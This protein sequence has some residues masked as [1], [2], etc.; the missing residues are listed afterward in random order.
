MK[1]FTISVL[2]ILGY[3]SNFSAQALQQCTTDNNNDGVTNTQ[4]FLNLVGQ[5]GQ[6]CTPVGIISSIT[7]TGVTN[8]GALTQG[9]EAT[10]VS[11]VISYA[12]GNGGNHTGQVVASTGVTGLYAALSAGSFNSGAGSL[13]YV[14][15]GTPATSGTASFALNIGGQTCILTRTVDAGN[16][17]NSTAHSCSATNVHNSAKNYGTLTDQQGNVY[18]TIVIGNQE[19]M[20]ENLRTSVYRNGESIANVTDNSQWA[21]LTTG[22][23]CYFENNSI[24]ECPYGKLYNWFTISDPRGVCPT[25]WHIPTDGEWTQLTNFLGGEETAGS[26][27]KSIGTDYWLSPNTGALNESGFSGLPGNYRYS[28]GEFQSTN[29]GENDFAAF[30]SLTE[31]QSIAA[32]G[33]YLYYSS[34]GINRGS[35]SKEEGHSI[36]CI[37]DA[38][39]PQGYIIGLNC[40]MAVN[41]GTLSLGIEANNVSSS[42]PYSFGN[43]GEHGG[44]FTTSTGVYGLTASLSIGSFNEGSGTLEFIINGTPDNFGEATFELNIGGQ[45]CTLTR[46]V[47]G[48]SQNYSSEHTCG[49][50]NIHN[51]E[52]TYGS[53]T[54]QQG[55]VYKTIVIG[56]QEWMAEN[57]KTTIY[58]NGNEIANITDDSQWQSLSSGAWCDFNNDIQYD[59]PYGKLYNY[60]AIADQRNLCPVGWHVPTDAEWTTLTTFLGGQNIAG[61]KMKSTGAQYWVSSNADATNESGLSCLPGGYRNFGG[62]YI[63]IG[64]YGAWW[65]STVV[66][67]IEA[68]H[69][70]LNHFSGNA[71]R[72]SDDLRFGFSVRCLRD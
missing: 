29:P 53:M 1:T 31:L 14:I 27:M 45:T 34:G 16:Q 62:S 30:W 23:W 66:G 61:G 65:S 70:G 67:G 11:S 59:C 56:N 28:N 21:G 17:T 43:G 48:G 22:A 6:N 24:Y 57:L 26:K 46:I 2:V 44:W 41:S 5:F 8:N 58:R 9:N 69:R 63:S 13:T 7:C 52:K 18:K 25:G 32:W 54:D 60:Y 35:A 12:G 49:A 36:R 42:I 40:D 38:N 50:T 51:P 3:H 55:N 33:R 47:E 37:K 68:W 10:N 72:G 19:W 64:D 20:A 39:P 71:L 4:D 15:L